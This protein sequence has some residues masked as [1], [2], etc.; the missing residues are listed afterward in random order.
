MELINLLMGKKKIIIMML[1]VGIFSLSVI[2]ANIKQD[3]IATLTNSVSNKKIGW[4][5]KRNDNHEQPDVG[6]Q[7]KKILEENKGIC[8]G[9]KETKT[10]YLTFD[11]G[12][13]AGYTEKILETLKQN[14][15]KAAFFITA[16]YVNTQEDLVKKMIDE[17]H[18][19]G[20]HTPKFL[21]SGNN[22]KVKC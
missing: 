15:V 11:E 3:E 4:G 8:L 6:T 2:S 19:V 12:Y 16:H 5:I 21:M 22:I 10:I 7:N 14:D 18:I 17:G 1:I 9:N 20:N 13:E